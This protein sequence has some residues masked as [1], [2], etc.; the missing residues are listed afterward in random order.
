[1]VG[2]RHHIV[3]DGQRHGEDAGQTQD[4]EGRHEAIS[5][6]GL[7]GPRPRQDRGESRDAELAPE[8]QDLPETDHAALRSLLLT[9]PLDARVVPETGH[10]ALRSLLLTEPSEARVVRATHPDDI[11]FIRTDRAEW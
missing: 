5:P 2:P 8:P 7:Q 3:G 9:E 6:R 11:H 1:M 4:Q 10:A